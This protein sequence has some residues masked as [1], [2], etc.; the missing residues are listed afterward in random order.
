MWLIPIFGAWFALKLAR[1]GQRP[2]HAGKTALWALAGFALNTVVFIAAFQLF[3]TSPPA[4]L[5][6]FGVGS[7]AAI[8]I[9]RRVSWSADGRSI[10][11]AV[12][13]GD[14]DIVLLDGLIKGSV[15]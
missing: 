14:A 10:F 15:R 4:Q 9:A 12:G 2:V 7:W 6:L 1:A 8:F 3:P 13:Q 5:A 11:A